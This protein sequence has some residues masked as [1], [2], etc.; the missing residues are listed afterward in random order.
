MTVANSLKEAVIHEK[1]H[2][3]LIN[4]LNQ[5]ELESLYDEL[6]EYHIQ[7]ISPTAAKDGAECIAEIGV[8]FD[9]G[10]TDWIPQKAKDLFNRYIGG[11]I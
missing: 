1:Y 8:L 7:G 6:S 9:R 2:A 5:N 4:G 3:K 11:I 10:D